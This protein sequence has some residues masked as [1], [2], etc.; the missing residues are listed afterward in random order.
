MLLSQ[1]WLSDSVLNFLDLQS[2][3]RLKTSCTKLHHREHTKQAWDKP[4]T[5][6]QQSV[7]RFPVTRV[8]CLTG[9]V[10]LN[11]HPT[12]RELDVMG[13]IDNVLPEGLTRLTLRLFVPLQRL[14][15]SLT[16]IRWQRCQYFIPP[17]HENVHTMIFDKY[18]TWHQDI[19]SSF[20]KLRRLVC[21]KMTNSDSLGHVRSRQLTHLF[22]PGVCWRGTLPNARVLCCRSAANL[23][24]MA[25]LEVLILTQARLTRNSRFPPNLKLLILFE[26]RRECVI[27]QPTRFDVR[28][29]AWSI[30]IEYMEQ[31]ND[32]LHARYLP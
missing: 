29:S 5:T 6:G 8:K 7:F 23:E 15:A 16:K 30:S 25:N 14:P 10:K 27:P 3:M 12:L 4:I 22:I 9:P 11:E 26:P 19:L 32:P 20:P 28:V 31:V 1:N 18:C 21:W 24:S 17:R 2:H 13:N